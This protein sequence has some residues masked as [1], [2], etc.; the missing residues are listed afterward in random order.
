MTQ[1]K[2]K[3]KSANTGNPS[4]PT[5][6]TRASTHPNTLLLLL[7]TGVEDLRDHGG[8]LPLQHGAEQPDDEEQAGAEHQQRHSQQDHTDGHVRHAHVHEEVPTCTR[9]FM[10]L[11][12][13]SALPDE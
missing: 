3:G 7:L 10:A 1:P 6:A 4:T 8:H 11:L 2:G 13:R 9:D 12:P 5:G